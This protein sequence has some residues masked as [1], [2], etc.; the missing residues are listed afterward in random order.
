MNSKLTY[1]K[2]QFFD[3]II[4]SHHGTRSYSKSFGLNSCLLT[5]SFQ[6]LFDLIL[7][8]LLVSSFIF[9]LINCSKETIHGIFL[10]RN[11]NI[12]QFY[13]T[14]LS[15]YFLKMFNLFLLAG[16][17]IS[18]FLTFSISCC[19]SVNSVS[20][21]LNQRLFLLLDFLKKLLTLSTKSLKYV[22][23]ALPASEIIL[24]KSS[25][26]LLIFSF[27]KSLFIN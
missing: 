2:L 27:E 14:I 20:D 24:L 18:L 12:Y 3:Q 25:N 21:N 9:R 22:K 1:V 17:F 11:L 16:K 26:N 4:M 6:F 10:F 15:L 13:L 7:P 5:L 23:T 19:V 8:N